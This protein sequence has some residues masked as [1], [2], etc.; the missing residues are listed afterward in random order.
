M[1]TASDQKDALVIVAL[2]AAGFALLVASTSSK[3]YGLVLIQKDQLV[4]S[5]ARTVP[6][7]CW[8]SLAGLLVLSREAVVWTSAVAAITASL[9]TGCT[10]AVL[11]APIG[12]DAVSLM[13]TV[14]Y[15]ALISGLICLTVRS[16]ILAG[17]V[18]PIL[19]VLQVLTDVIAHLGMGLIQ[20]A[21]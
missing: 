15:Y 16:P 19:L 2:T 4:W 11:G 20:I 10:V 8:I 12:L 14:S 13:S 18:G 21:C 5:L 9:I 3:D 17:I 7:L 1:D 6:A